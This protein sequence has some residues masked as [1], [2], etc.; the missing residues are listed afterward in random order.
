MELA[1]VVMPILLAVA[2]TLITYGIYRWRHAA[3]LSVV[4]LAASFVV[5]RLGWAENPR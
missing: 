3:D 2:T 1:I 4:V 5:A